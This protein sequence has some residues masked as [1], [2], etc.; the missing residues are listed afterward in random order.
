MDNAYQGA[1]ATVDVLAQA[2][3]CANNGTSAQTASGWPVDGTK[4]G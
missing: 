2:V 1:T 4:T 3:Q